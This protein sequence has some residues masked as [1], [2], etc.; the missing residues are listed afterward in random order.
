MGNE[1]LDDD[2]L[3]AV[4]MDSIWN[5]H[6]AIDNAAAPLS[7]IARPTASNPATTAATTAA[8]TKVAVSA[9]KRR[10]MSIDI[11]NMDNCLALLNE[12]ATLHK[13]AR[14]HTPEIADDN[15]C[16]DLS[17][18][19]SDSMDYAVLP[20]TRHASNDVPSANVVS[21]LH[22][23]V[24][25]VTAPPRTLS[26]GWLTCRPP[27]P[28]RNLSRP[29]SRTLSMPP[30]PA[31][32]T[33]ADLVSGRRISRSSS[34]A[35]AHVVPPSSCPSA[36]AGAP[37]SA[38]VVMMQRGVVYSYATTAITPPEAPTA[39]TLEHYAVL[40]KEFGHSQF[41]GLQWTVIDAVVNQR[42]DVCCVSATGSGK[43]LCYQFP[44]VFQKGTAL[45]VSPLISLMED[46]T[47][48]LLARGIP[49]TFLGSANKDM[50]ETIGRL[51]RG[52]YRVVYATP[53]FLTAGA[54]DLMASWEREKVFSLVAIDEAHCVSQ[55]GHDFRSSYRQLGCI[56]QAMP[57]TPVIA[58]TATA[59]EGV[60]HDI[61][62]SL[63]LKTPLVLCSSFDRPNLML[64]AR[65][66]TGDV[67]ADL[68][69]YF[70]GRPKGG[71]SAIVYCPTKKETERVA[72]ELSSLGI[73]CCHYHAGMGLK[74]RKEA[75][76][77]FSLD[78]VECCV[79]TIA[80]GMG[81]DKPDVRLVIHYGSPRDVESYYQEIG[82][83]GRDGQKGRCVAFHSPSD[84]LVN[85]RAIAEIE[86]ETHRNHRLKMMRRMEEYLTAPQ[87][88]RR[89]IISHFDPTATAPAPANA[90]CGSCDNCCAAIDRLT[91]AGR[92][93]AN[94]GDE[95]ADANACEG[96]TAHP[97]Q[98]FGDNKVDLSAE[99][100]LLLHSIVVA[101]GRF[102]LGFSLEVLNGK[103]PK[104]AWPSKLPMI[105]ANPAFGAGKAHSD[106]WWRG[107]FKQLEALQLVAE[108]AVKNGFGFTAVVTPDGEAWLAKSDDG[109]G[110]P[111]MLRQTDAMVS[112]DRKG[113]RGKSWAP[114]VARGSSFGSAGRVGGGGGSGLN[115]DVGG[116]YVSAAPVDPHFNGM[117]EDLF[118]LRKV[119]AEETHESLANV[120]DT[121]TL[122][123]I[124]SAR[125]GSID[126]LRAVEGVR[127]AF[128]ALHGLRFLSAVYAYC[129]RAGATPDP[130]QAP[131]AAPEIDF[132]LPPTQTATLAMFM[133]GMEM[134]DIARERTLAVGTIE[135]HLC[136]ALAAGA[137]IDVRKLG[138]TR[139]LYD[140][141]TAVCT[142]LSGVP[143]LSTLK[144]HLPDLSWTHLKAVSIMLSLG[145]NMPQDS[146]ED[147]AQCDDNPNAGANGEHSN[148]T[149]SDSVVVD[150]VVT[151]TNQEMQ[152][153]EA[154]LLPKRPHMM[155]ASSASLH[156]PSAVPVTP[157][158]PSAQTTVSA[159]MD[160]ATDIL[161]WIRDRAPVSMPITPSTPS[162]IPTP[163]DA[164]ARKRQLPASFLSTRSTPKY[165]RTGDGLPHRKPL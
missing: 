151:P 20:P 137:D 120:L 134:A 145:L 70:A 132:G 32:K 122:W 159:A 27:S 155:V 142:K 9:G 16:V 105:R 67:R 149:E 152:A 52:E 46:Q 102:G 111:L 146:A 160:E 30:V 11:D 10:T 60:Q 62:K 45:V 92:P 161:C 143:T 84:S 64:E 150:T 50:G 80:F 144:A 17:A 5:N 96:D 101:G 56:K 91:K 19:R 1:S 8:T 110:G 55:W 94:F 78:R 76:D 158:T 77:Q 125:P 100:R 15:D 129:A 162:S 136:A 22:R 33:V 4:D 36:D 119:I 58:L 130:K 135:S 2:L 116:G 71:W 65:P 82:R 48:A 98:L 83:C 148:A 157:S 103:D 25:N 128:V 38:P 14:A 147:N 90:L 106:A 73:K 112:A 23:A 47:R 35:E 51:S 95:D 127:E 28:S 139:D 121:T 163:P 43:S 114:A 165:A 44:A 93:P 18:L 53:E 89:F 81:I 26:S 24:V 6:I 7:D 29:V 87:C 79:A 124:A 3:G 37:S 117:V 59:T 107:L 154:D 138:V 86:N 133:R 108:A 109:E 31:I 97:S 61:C 40:K 131:R 41:R 57:T 126:S 74:D 123:A 54:H 13:N 104:K 113:N 72:A 164:S 115:S 66:K 140:R 153:T 85:A 42:R 141:I 118:E 75:H 21:H 69:P 156:R 12:T 99:A 63:S 88:R 49:A 68:A 34:D 39:P